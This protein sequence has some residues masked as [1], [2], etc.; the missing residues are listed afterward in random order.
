MIEDLVTIIQANDLCNRWGLD[1]ISTS[2][3]IAFLLEAVEK[4]FVDIPEG[5]PSITWGNGEAVIFLLHRIT[6]GEGIG[7]LLKKDVRAFAEALGGEAKSFA[8]HVKGLELAYHDPRAL[9]SLAVAYATHPRG[10]VT[11]GAAIT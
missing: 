5:Y 2:G 10:H 1:T 7:N 9:S 4:G 8:M 11:G 6:D 3:S